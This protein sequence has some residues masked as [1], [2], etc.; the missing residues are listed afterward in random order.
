[1]RAADIPRGLY[2]TKCSLSMN[3]QPPASG[4]DELPT[5]VVPRSDQAV[6]TPPGGHPAAEA[7]VASTSHPANRVS[8]GAAEDTNL[9]GTTLGGYRLIRKIARGGMGQVYEALQTTLDRKV[10]VKILTDELAHRPEFLRRFEREAKAAAAL[11]HPNLVQVHDFGEADGRLFLV[12]EYVEGQDLAVRVRETGKM[13]VAEALEVIGQAA[14][15]LRAAHQKSIIHR[16][17]KPA[18]LLRT[19]DGTIKVSDLG[20]AKVLTEQTPDLTITSAGMG[21]P[22]FMAPEQAHGTRPVDHRADMYSLGITLFYLLTGRFAYEG[23]TPYSIVLAHANTPLPSPADFGIELPAAV[24]AFLERLTAKQAEDRYQSYD[25]LLADLELVKQGLPPATQSRQGGLSAR[26]KSLLAIVLMLVLGLGGWRALIAISKSRTSTT[27][28]A[29]DAPAKAPPPSAADTSFENSLG[30]QFREVGTL[31]GGQKR[32]LAAIWKTRVQDF[33][34]FV[35]EAKYDATQGMSSVG[36]GGW[37]WKERG[38]TWKKPGFD[39]APDHPV[40]GVSWQDAVEFCQ[41]L[42]RS[43]RQAGRIGTND[44]YRLPTDA[45]WSLLVGTNNYPWGDTYPPAQGAGNYA[46]ADAKTTYKKIETYHDGFTYTSPVGRYKPNRLGLYDVGGNLWEWCA[47]WYRKELN[48]EQVRQEFPAMN[49]DGGGQALRV[50]RGASWHE[51]NA[52]YLSSAFRL[53]AGPD[54]R[55]DNLGFRC[56]L[57]VGGSPR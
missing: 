54:V 32:L 43:E 52:L 25:A 50:L 37:S 11:N 14:L 12:M 49:D 53:R 22:H 40:C 10:A 31:E 8:W 13:P 2:G 28:A 20:L 24:E 55:R 9:S 16:D 30:M 19:R 23:T 57:V 29:T 35:A 5:R 7:N 41:W 17:I 26:L 4:P 15:A 3:D 56:V 1:M 18:N 27:K 44:E 47:D 45:E 36:P 6:L 48:S 34:A 21:S 39:Q 38:D 51:E 46:D 33:S 42:T